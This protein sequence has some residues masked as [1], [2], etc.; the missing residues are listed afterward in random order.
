M[1][2]NQLSRIAAAAVMTFGVATS[3]HATVSLTF[4]DVTTGNS[5]SCSTATGICSGAGAAAFSVTTSFDDNTTP[6]NAKI[7]V[8]ATNWFGWSMGGSLGGSFSAAQYG[9]T[10]AVLNLDNFSITRS[11]VT[12]TL[13]LN[14]IG[15]DYSMPPGVD[16]ASFGS[17]SMIRQSGPNLTDASSQFTNFYADDLGGDPVVGD[18]LDGCLS[19]GVANSRSCSISENWQDAGGGDFSMRI[20]QEIRLEQGR[21]VKTQASLTTT[22]AVPEPMTLSLVGAALLGAAALSRRQSKKA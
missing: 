16:K 1:I 21:T 2:A 4:L 13:N 3:A 19:T 8:T 15:K 22:A 10:E 20:A 17:S 5:V 6:G 11:G 7:E 9:M 14:A 18:L 12:G